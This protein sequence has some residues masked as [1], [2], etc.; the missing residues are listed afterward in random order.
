MTPARCDECRKLF[1]ANPVLQAELRHMAAIYG[2]GAA[3]AEL[4]ERLEEAHGEHGGEQP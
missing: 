1:M 4:N 3:E 2:P